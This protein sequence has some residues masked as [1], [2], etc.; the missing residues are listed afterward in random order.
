MTN[1]RMLFLRVFDELYS[2]NHHNVIDEYYDDE[3][4]AIRFTRFYD[5]EIDLIIEYENAQFCVYAIN[6]RDNAFRTH[7][8]ND[9]ID[10]AYDM[11]E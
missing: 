8:V 9:V 10:F 4:F 11:Y 5:D 1:T 2:M 3:K 6:A 7:D